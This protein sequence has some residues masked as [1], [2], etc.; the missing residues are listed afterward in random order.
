MHGGY[1]VKTYSIDGE[2]RPVVQLPERAPKELHAVGLDV[3]TRW[4]AWPDRAAPLCVL[5]IEVG[6]HSLELLFGR[7][8]Q[9][10][11]KAILTTGSLVLALQN[12]ITIGIPVTA[13]DDPVVAVLAAA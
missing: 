2:G 6:G 4:M 9:A 11:L 8:H 13:D 10:L 3:T 5:R 12:D 7:P 1:W